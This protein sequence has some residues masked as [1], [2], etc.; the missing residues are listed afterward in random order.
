MEQ[1]EQNLRDLAA[2]FAMAGLISR[3]K[4]ADPTS[5]AKT[6]YVFADELMAERKGDHAEE[7]IAAI[8]KRRPRHSS[9]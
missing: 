1:H 7:G 5:T 3:D 8:R 9:D 2:I 6:A 4:R